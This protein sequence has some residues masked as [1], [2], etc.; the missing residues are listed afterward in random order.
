MSFARARLF[1][2]SITFL[3]FAS[4]ATAQTS[5]NPK[6]YVIEA[7]KINRAIKLTGTLSDPLWK[8]A[9]SVELKYE[10]QPGENTPAPQKTFF[11]VLYNS[12]YIY[13]GFN[14]LDSSVKLIRAHIADHDNVFD[15]DFVGVLLDTYGTMQGG[16][17]FFVNPYAVQGD[18]MRTGSNEDASFDCVWYSAAHINDSGWTAEM[19]IP[20]KSLRFSSLDKQHWIVLPVRNLPRDSRYQ[21]TWMPIARD[22]PC[23][24]C[25]GGTIVGISGISTSNNVEVLPYAMGLQSSMLNDTGDPT[26]K[27]ENEPVMGRIGAGI[28]YAPS[29]SFVLAGVVNPD[30][31]QIESD[32]T[33]ISINSTFAIFYPEKRPFFL[34]GAELY[35]TAASIFY[36]RMIN[37]P[38]ASVKLSE[39][40]GSF[41]LAY[42][43]AEDRESPFIIPG[44][45]GSD[46]VSSHLKSWSNVVRGKYNLGK[47]SFIGGLVTTRNFS[48]AHNYVGTIDWN[49]LFAENFYFTGQAGVSNTKEINDSSLFSSGRHF[50]ST[51][52]T[53][54]FDGENYT[55]SGFQT[56]IMR[57]ARDYSFDLNLV[58]VTPTFQA[59]DGFITQNDFRQVS[60]WQGYTMYFDN[61][62]IEQIHPQIISG[63][64]FNNNDGTRKSEWGAIEVWTQLKAQTQLWVKYY[65]V[66]EEFFHNVRFRNL[67]R[68]EAGVYSVPSKALQ[69]NLWAQVG[70]LVYHE[71]TP[72]LGRGY[73]TTAEITVKPTDRF[74]FD[75]S[76]AH[77]RLWSFYSNRLFFDGYI[78]RV[79]TV[80]NFTPELFVRVISQYDGFAKQLQ[81][82]PLFSFKL[83][84]FT[85]F[86]AGSVHNLTD[87]G[88]RIGMRQTARQFFIKLQYLW[89]E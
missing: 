19:A 69:I 51:S 26:S 65:P 11:S 54:T 24:F 59:Q 10:I 34:E 46:F 71:D 66:Q 72:E 30:F 8:T 14:C 48:D 75:F 3:V 78:A 62:F 43:G 61:L 77:S 40:K 28:R 70:R 88:N 73:N 44:N 12:D 9:S 18:L 52:H 63:A 37:D 60:L 57:N 45:E 82:D 56:D 89:R 13:F 84:P 41:S 35:S 47:E 74:S 87:F 25:Q 55:G 83:N 33:Q 21:I 31:S 1:S 67:Y 53:A 32:A 4:L 80:Y 27:F 2:A 81:I 22:N 38:L 49:I 7:I 29:S 86:Y 5:D 50:G 36:S 68:T 58:S 42:L 16:Y 64:S 20:F 6:K 23:V 79:V 39:K 15:D 85:V 17:E 76:Y